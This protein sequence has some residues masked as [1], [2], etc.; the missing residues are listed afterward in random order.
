MNAKIA[1]PLIVATIGAVAMVFSAWIG[2][3]PDKSTETATHFVPRNTNP[4]LTRAPSEAALPETRPADVAP[5]HDKTP[6]PSLARSVNV[7]QN[8][9][10]GQNIAII[11]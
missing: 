6:S 9:D 11:K 7:T 3:Q 5:A 8:N 2:K 4:S 1:V 10:S